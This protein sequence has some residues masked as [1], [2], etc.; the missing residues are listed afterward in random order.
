M[1]GVREESVYKLT[2][3]PIQ[4]LAHDSTS[5]GELWHRRLAHQHY[6]ALPSLRT[7]VTGLP[8]LF[9]VDC[10]GICRGCALGKNAKSSFPSSDRRSKG[11][12]DLVHSN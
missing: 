11:I 2:T 10:D 4:A 9:R 12:L 7:M 1:I 6:R 5:L 3:Q 8:I